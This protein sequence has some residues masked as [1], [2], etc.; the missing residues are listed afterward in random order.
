M[1]SNENNNIYESNIGFLLMIS[2]SDSSFIPTPLVLILQPNGDTRV[3]RFSRTVIVVEGLSEEPYVGHDSYES[4]DLLDKI[5]GRLIFYWTNDIGSINW[6]ELPAFGDESVGFTAL[7]QE[8]ESYTFHSE[9]S[10]FHFNSN[11]RTFSIDEDTLMLFVNPDYIST[12]NDYRPK[13]GVGDKSMLEDS[14]LYENITFYS[15]SADGNVDI[16]II[17][18][19]SCFSD[20]FSLMLT[21]HSPFALSLR[22]YN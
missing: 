9:T 13:I 22:I 3:F 7:N 16:V 12:Y 11:S 10:Q 20:T 5:D 1:V 17:R 14:K 4:Q 21:S 8:D 6:V 15:L 19:Y 18:G 2:L